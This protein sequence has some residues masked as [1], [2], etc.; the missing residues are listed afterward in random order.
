MPLLAPSVP[1]NGTPRST[2]NHA[3]N[4]YLLARLST[5]APAGT[6]L[7]APPAITPPRAMSTF[8]NAK[9]HPANDGNHPSLKLL[10]SNPNRNA[11]TLD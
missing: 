11:P 9:L 8:S 2:Q 1:D 6:T 7:D 10:A 5:N 4:F 3:I